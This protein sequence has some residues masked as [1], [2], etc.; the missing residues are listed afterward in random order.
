M[1]R[2]SSMSRWT[3]IFHF[4]SVKD[5]VLAAALFCSSGQVTAPP[6]DC[7]SWKMASE[8]VVWICGRTACRLVFAIVVVFFDIFPA[9]TSC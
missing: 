8:K 7:N 3:Y 9:S 1:L 2:L 6:G 5:A 4:F